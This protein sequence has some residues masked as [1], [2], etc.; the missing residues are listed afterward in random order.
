MAL[1]L[2]N[3]FVSS[4]LISAS[5]ILASAPSDT[6][7]KTWREFSAETTH[8]NIEVIQKCDMIF[9][10]V[11]PHIFPKVLENIKNSLEREFVTSESKLFVSIMAGTKMETLS[12]SL[13]EIV[14][15]P[16]IIRVHPNTPAMVGEGCA[17][18][19]LGEG[20]YNQRIKIPWFDKLKQF[21]N[22]WIYF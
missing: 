4:G 1:A 18:Y 12:G 13:K 11:K 5:Q 15:S 16:R 3:G 8:D 17:V 21:V 19:S 9:L 14:K 10:S 20:T 22:I 7:L 2:A 6:N